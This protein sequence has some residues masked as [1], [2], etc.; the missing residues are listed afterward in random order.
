MRSRERCNTTYTLKY[1]ELLLCPIKLLS[2]FSYS[3]KRKKTQD[4]SNPRVKLIAVRFYASD[5]AESVRFFNENLNNTV[6]NKYEPTEAVINPQ[7]PRVV[8][9]Y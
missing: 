8:E 5:C 1:E 6:D 7:V 2:H 4:S 3:T 9:S